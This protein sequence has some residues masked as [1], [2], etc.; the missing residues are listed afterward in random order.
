MKNLR[1]PTFV[2]ILTL[3]TAGVLTMSACTT[4]DDPST[5]STSSASGAT[6]T[7]ASSSSGT[8]GGGGGGPLV[9]GACPDGYVSECATIQV[10]LDHAHPEGEKIDFHFS[11]YPAAT[12]PAKRQVW[13]LAGGPGQAGYVFGK[14]IAALAE[15]MPDADLFAADH[16]G[17]GKSHRLTC[18]QQ[19]APNSYGG[20]ILD[21]LDAEACLEALKPKGD[22]DRLAHFTTTEAASDVLDGIAAVRTSPDEKVFVIGAS[23]G[24]HWAH[25][26]VQISAADA[27]KPRLDGVVFDGFL[28][29]G[30]FAFLDYDRAAEEAGEALAAACDADA[31]CTMHLGPGGALAKVKAVMATLEQTPCGPFT[32]DQAR[33]LISVLLD[34]W[35]GRAMIFPAIHR[36]ERCTDADQDALVHLAN[37]YYGLLQMAYQVPFVNSG[38]LQNNIVLNEL[39]KLPGEAEPT[40]AEML[41]AAD[42]QPFLAGGSLPGRLVDMRAFWPVPPDDFSALPTPAPTTAKLLWLGAKMDA[43]AWPSQ[44]TKITSVYPDAPFVFLDGASHTPMNQSPLTSDPTK[45]CGAKIAT[46]FIEADGV[47]DASCQTNDLLPLRLEA[48]DAEFAIKWWDTADD[49]GDGTP[50]PPATNPLPSPGPSQGHWNALPPSHWPDVIGSPGVPHE[51]VTQ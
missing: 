30:H 39:W 51:I 10:P 29:P 22:Y 17:T 43:H 20:Y 37:T 6:T 4:D 40:K 34:P 38:I 45:T 49:W 13:L 3:T 47:L 48:P 26:M 15:A 50:K 23:Y 28:T 46:S 7:S 14:R 41:A 42:A 21:E 31:S 35:G 8:G 11:R 36:L 44:S 12:Q 1:T 32:K 27:T 16:R 9:Y 5:T 25:R 33:T 19:D 2:S 18:P 24:T